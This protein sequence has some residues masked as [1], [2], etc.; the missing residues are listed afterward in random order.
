MG[1]RNGY[2]SESEW[3]N[4]VLEIKE[5]Q[6]QLI[7]VGISSPKKEYVIDYLM[8]QGINAVFMGVGGSFDVLA[9][10]IKRAPLWVQHCHLE[11]FFRM[12]QEPRRLFKRYIFGNF[13]FLKLI[14]TEKIKAK[15]MELLSKESGEQKIW[16]KKK[17]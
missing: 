1:I 4:V 9:E 16:I 6:P 12:I 11:W 17:L 7:F 2:F 8:N 13:K 14:A 5:S 3:E 10:E 15:K